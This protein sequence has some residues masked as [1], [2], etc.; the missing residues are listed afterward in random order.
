VQT[1]FDKPETPRL[2]FD[3][4]QDALDYGR[5][6]VEDCDRVLVSKSW[7]FAER[8]QKAEIDIVLKICF[9]LTPGSNRSNYDL[10]FCA[11]PDGVVGNLDNASALEIPSGAY[12][13]HAHGNQD[14]VLLYVGYPVEC[15]EKIVSSFVWLE[16]PKERMNLM[17]NICT[18]SFERIL[19][20]SGPPGKG[21]GSA[22]GIEHARG[23]GGG[24]G[25]L[26]ERGA[27]IA[28]GVESDAVE[29]LRQF[30]GEHNC[31]DDVLPLRVGTK[32]TLVWA[33][34]AKGPEF[35]F[36][37]TDVMLCPREGVARTIERV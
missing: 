31:D 36:E 24:V 14:C 19:E 7:N 8:Y 27:E 1:S 2:R 22:L 13:S 17:R 10:I 16:P 11:I 32:H 25:S 15:A 28:N 6:L 30:L 20:V 21:E 34:I 33:F 3:T 26:V 35:F 29:S 9:A 12:G 37:I 5:Q 23:E 18:S 4:Q